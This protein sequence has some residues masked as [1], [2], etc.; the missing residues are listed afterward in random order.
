MDKKVKWKIISS[1]TYLPN[2]M[3]I[4]KYLLVMFVFII[5]SIQ[6]MNTNDLLWQCVWSLSLIKMVELGDK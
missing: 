6:W 3:V 4:C 2:L 1:L 5:S